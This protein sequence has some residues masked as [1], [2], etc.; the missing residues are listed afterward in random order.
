MT[1]PVATLG[2]I[3]SV[4]RRG[5]CLFPPNV[6]KPV[7]SK[8]LIQGR[9]IAKAGDILTP[10]KG[11]WTCNGGGTC[12]LPRTVVSTSKV[13]VGGRP[14]AHIGDFTSLRT[15]RRILSGNPKVLMN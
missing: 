14:V 12:I 8:V 6:V 11:I 3:D 5:C 4:S 2:S 1:R 7:V 9:P 15:R 10:V 13:L